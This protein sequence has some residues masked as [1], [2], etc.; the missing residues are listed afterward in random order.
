MQV[1]LYAGGF[2]IVSKSGVGQAIL[3]QRAMLEQAGVAVTDK[4]NRSAA[5]IHINTVFPD[6]LFAA[7]LARIQGRKV[8]YYGHSTMEDF[9]NSFRG[10]NLLA[11]LFRRWLIHCYKRGDIIITPTPYSKK[12]LEG[13]GIKKPIYSLTNGIDTHFFAPN[14]ERRLAFRT[15][16]QLLPEQK[17][18]VSA[19]HYIERKGILDFIELARRL[20]QIRFFWFGYTNPALVPAPISGAIQNA[21]ANLSFPGYVSQEELR[22]AYCGCDLFAFLSQ[23]ETEGIVILEALACGIPTLVRRIPVYEGWLIDRENVYMAKET[24]EFARLT[25]HILTGEVPDL[26]VAGMEVAKERSLEA[27]GAALLAIYR[28]EN[29]IGHA[30]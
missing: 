21:P 20:P 24:G 12:L 28:A 30:V 15:R 1:M 18:V 13:Y 2:S 8:I 29:I 22:D 23:E 16:Y 19:G 4:W 25:E 27:V 10:S 3:H 26:S 14:G 17:A 11:P 6:S 7:W 5:V 9:R